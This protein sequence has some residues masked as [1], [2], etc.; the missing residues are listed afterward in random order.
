MPLSTECAPYR[1][2]AV[3]MTLAGLCKAATHD[4]IEAQGWSLNPVR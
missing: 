1:G 2:E 3:A 4:A